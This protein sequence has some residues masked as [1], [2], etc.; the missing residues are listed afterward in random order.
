MPAFF[1]FQISDIMH[2]N[3]M[4][5]LTYLKSHAV[6]SGGIAIVAVAG[7]IIAGRV[8]Q[9]GSLPEANT[10]N[11]KKVTLISVENFRDDLS[12][13]SA[14]GIVE[15]VSQVDLKSQMSAP[16]SVVNVSVGDTVYTGQT[17]AVL[18]NADIRAQ[19]D[20]ARAGL[21]LAEGQYAGSGI[22][23]E[24]A[25]KSAFE[26]LRSGYLAADEI[27]NIQLGRF[28]FESTNGEPSLSSL[29][30]IDERELRESIRTHYIASRDSF[31]TWKGAIDAVS[32]ASDNSKIISA[33]TFSQKQLQN[34]AVLLD[35][36]SAALTT[37]SVKDFSSTYSAISGW[38]QTVTAARGSVNAS[39]KALTSA[40]AVLSGAQ[41]TYE[42]PAEAQ[43]SSAR[44][45]V[46]NLEAQLAKTVIT[47]P[48]TGK[49]AALPL[50]TGEL[51]QPGQLIATV[52]GGGGLQVKAYA[53]PEDLLKIKTGAKALIQ[54]SVMATVASV[55]PSVNQTN[56][57]IEVKITVNNP[58]A[59]GLVIGQSVSV[60]IESTAQ[61]QPTA[62]DNNY[63]LPIQNVK[64]VPGAA[65]VFTI[66]TDSKI[67][68]NP[69]T[70]GKIQG[71]FVEITSG[72]TSDMKIVSPVYELEEG[73]EVVSQ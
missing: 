5:I 28:L 18:Q 29:I 27:I 52:V 54:N 13:V 31:I 67:V 40:E 1:F 6:L 51:A 35:E 23:L 46:K 70:L 26:T 7:M 45:V 12:K 57:K 15:S 49:I 32:A 69:V 9:R 17:I 41:V 66:D 72:I 59:S 38:Q 10:S 34:I 53:S 64:I 63:I 8:A 65:Y 55:A 11:I 56:K 50:R 62:K 22:S 37:D 58:D 44:A 30:A 16:L 2:I 48:I 71:D 19:L 24:S 47:S 61:V 20:Q 33:I 21:R 73:N 60:S 14:D 43:I 39:T 3:T 4:K 68:K 42:S 36:V 25:Q